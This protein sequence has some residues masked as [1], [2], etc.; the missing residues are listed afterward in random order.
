MPQTPITH[1]PVPY[2]GVVLTPEALV[3]DDGQTLFLARAGGRSIVAS[4]YASFTHAVER[5]KDTILDVNSQEGR[6]RHMLEVWQHDSAVWRAGEARRIE[7]ARRGA[8]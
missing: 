2:F 1:P 3:M 8:H 7:Q 6:G 5:A 4:S